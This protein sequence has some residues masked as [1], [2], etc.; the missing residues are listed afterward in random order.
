MIRQSSLSCRVLSVDCI[1]LLLLLFVPDS[2]CP[3][4]SAYSGVR[5]INLRRNLPQH[6]PGNPRL[7]GIVI[8]CDSDITDIRFDT[9][10]DQKKASLLSAY[11]ADLLFIIRA[12][13]NESIPIAIS[14]PVGVLL[15]GRLGAPDSV[16][17][18]HKVQ[19]TAAYTAA[20]KAAAESL[21]VPYVDIR[22]ATLAA[23]PFYRQYYLG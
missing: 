20:T 18:H 11:T 6:L 1:S 19:A 16:R 9:L 22:S 17:Y 3:Q 23:I 12:A 13:Q 21:S 14:S 15:E 8:M 5:M 7:D 2:H 4:A 10:T